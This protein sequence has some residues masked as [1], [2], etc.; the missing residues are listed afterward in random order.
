MSVVVDASVAVKWFV[1]EPLWEE[2]RR[3]VERREPLYAPDLIF[4][5]VTNAAWKMVRR[6]EIDRDQ[7]FVMTAAIGIPFSRV[8]P[9][10]LLHERALHIALTIEHPIYDCLYLACAE[11]ADAVLVTADARLCDAVAA[12]PYA[13]LV[14]H[15]SEVTA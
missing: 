13:G 9:S 15:L 2:A 12:G 3:L 1:E 4:A 11:T 10:S 5:E 8:L 14:R 7:A 6:N